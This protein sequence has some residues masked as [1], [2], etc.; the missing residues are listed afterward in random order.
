[1]LYT[2]LAEAGYA[3]PWW[4]GRHNCPI[5]LRVFRERKTAGGGADAMAGSAH[6]N[7]VARFEVGPARVAQCDGMRIQD[8]LRIGF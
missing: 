5:A 8:A 4:F 3:E 2:A 6:L 1:M 7:Y